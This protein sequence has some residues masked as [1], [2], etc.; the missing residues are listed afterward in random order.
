[1]KQQQNTEKQVSKGRLGN[2][3]CPM[4]SNPTPRTIDG[5]YLIFVGASL[6]FCCSF[7][8]MAYP[9][10]TIKP[11]GRRLRSLAKEYVTWMVLKT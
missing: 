10:S 8:G 1:M 4:G 7:I 3:R 5:T 2:R 9:E 6:R 11:I